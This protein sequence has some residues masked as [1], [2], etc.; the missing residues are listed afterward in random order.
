MQSLS[1]SSTLSALSH[2]IV[3]PT[4]ETL[5]SR[6]P[7][8]SSNPVWSP[9]VSHEARSA[10]S[11]LERSTSSPSR[12]RS[13]KAR[14]VL[15]AAVV[16]LVDQVFVRTAPGATS[17]SCSASSTH[18][19]ISWPVARV[20][21]VE[22]LLPLLLCVPVGIAGSAREDLERRDDDEQHDGEQADARHHRRSRRSDLQDAGTE[23][24]DPG[25]ER[26]DGGEQ[27]DHDRHDLRSGRSPAVARRSPRGADLHHERQEEC[28]Q[29]S[30]RRDDDPEDQPVAPEPQVVSRRALPGGGLGFPGRHR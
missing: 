16:P 20:Q 28:D 1:T 19:C 21:V 7:F 6:R 24:S 2:E 4:E 13:W 3:A 30:D 29:D 11:A 12:M 15:L 25:D 8:R 26:W 9:S 27:A 23:R 22:F 17:S 5:S 14:Q 18:S 10:F